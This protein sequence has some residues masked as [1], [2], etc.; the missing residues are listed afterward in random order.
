MS[1][2]TTKPASLTSQA[3]DELRTRRRANANKLSVLDTVP[4]PGSNVLGT[5]HFDQSGSSPPQAVT[6]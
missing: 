6:S 3:G 2:I 4:T 1:P 5:E